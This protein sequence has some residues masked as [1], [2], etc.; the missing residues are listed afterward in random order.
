ME[1]G[2]YKKQLPAGTGQISDGHSGFGI[3]SVCVC[4]I[5]VS[6]VYN[7]Q[8]APFGHSVLVRVPGIC[9]YRDIY[10]GLGTA[11]PGTF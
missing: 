10:A 1:P 4:S 2:I 7:T 8:D 5:T 3:E 6:D 9:M 11:F